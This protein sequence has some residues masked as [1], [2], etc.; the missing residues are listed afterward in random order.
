MASLKMK[1]IRSMK[2]DKLGEKVLDLRKTLMKLRMQVAGGT[3]P[4]NPGMIRA[5]R[6]SLARVKT[7]QN[8]RSKTE[9]ASNK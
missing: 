2:A 8:Q 5:I 9:V 4:E 3:P 1:D 6:R 7:F